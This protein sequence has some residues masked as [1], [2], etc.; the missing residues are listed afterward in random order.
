M[1]AA[2]LLIVI[3][4]S[5]EDDPSVTPS[6]VAEPADKFVG[7]YIVSDTG[8][9]SCT[10]VSG[11]AYYCITPMI[12][13]RHHESTITKLGYGTFKISN[14]FGDSLDVNWYI[15]PTSSNNIG[16]SGGNVHIKSPGCEKEVLNYSG[17]E[18]SPDGYMSA[19]GNTITI[20]F[21]YNGNIP[22]GSKHRY[23]ENHFTSVFIRK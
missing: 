14:F 7:T 4:C 1:I 13:D 20:S 3:G 17:S 5:K 16:I 6:P 22:V 8:Y 15:S 19:D 21:I 11:N 18:Y 9:Y 2:L 10:D 23:Y 12:I